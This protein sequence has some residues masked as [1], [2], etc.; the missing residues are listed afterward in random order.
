MIKKISCF[1]KTLLSKESQTSFIYALLGYI[2]FI[3][4]RGFYSDTVFRFDKLDTL[5]F[6]FAVYL[7]CRLVI[8]SAKHTETYEL[9]KRYEEIEEGF[10]SI[11]AIRDKMGESAQDFTDK[12]YQILVQKSQILKKDLESYQNKQGK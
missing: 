4:L 10:K 6:L 3:L 5:A 11:K 2:I 1:F 9:L 7:I 8:S 12:A